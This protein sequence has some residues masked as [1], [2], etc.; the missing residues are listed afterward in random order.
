MAR[1]AVFSEGRGLRARV[2]RPYAGQGISFPPDGCR[3]RG[4]LPGT[5]LG[6]AMVPSRAC[7]ARPSAKPGPHKENPRLQRRH[8]SVRRDADIAGVRSPPLRGGQPRTRGLAGKGPGITLG[9]GFSE[10]RGLRA[11]RYMRSRMRSRTPSPLPRQLG[12]YFFSTR[13][14]PWDIFSTRGWAFGQTIFRRSS[15]EG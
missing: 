13:G 1:R 5:C 2:A 6:G 3:W 8:A 9:G 14:G 4:G 10:G 11:C 12:P 7:G 15:H